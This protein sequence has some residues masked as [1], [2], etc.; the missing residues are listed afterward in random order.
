MAGL[1]GTNALSREVVNVLGGG[2]SSVGT[3]YLGPAYDIPTECASEVH[4]HR[5]APLLH[6]FLSLAGS[7]LMSPRDIEGAGVS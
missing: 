6:A 7:T 2:R 5:R 1:A 4:W 3:R